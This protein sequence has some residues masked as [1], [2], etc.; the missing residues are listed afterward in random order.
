M[1]NKHIEK[2][3]EDSVE[4][5]IYHK[6]LLPIKSHT[7]SFLVANIWEAVDDSVLNTVRTPIANHLE[8]WIKNQLTA[9]RK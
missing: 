1:N 5:A 3:I 7:W 4:D 8:D 9:K 2:A 6:H